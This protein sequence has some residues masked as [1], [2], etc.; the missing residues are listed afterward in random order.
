MSS[1]ELAAIERKMM[2]GASEAESK[3]LIMQMVADS[4]G[5]RRMLARCRA[6]HEKFCEVLWEGM[7][8]SEDLERLTEYYHQLA[9]LPAPVADAHDIYM[10]FLDGI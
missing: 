2:E 9:G 4:P 5:H 10:A 3:A 6:V 8:L 1:N 7:A